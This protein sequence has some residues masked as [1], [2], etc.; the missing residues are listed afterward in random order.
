MDHT[1]A[2][3][4]RSERETSLSDVKFTDRPLPARRTREL[5]TEATSNVAGVRRR[6]ILARR[7]QDIVVEIADGERLTEIQPFWIALLERSDEPNVFMDPAL[8]RV[9]ADVYPKIKSVALL[10]WRKGN[11]RSELVGVW[12]FAVGSARHS[13]L[14]VRILTAPPFVHGYA[15]TPVVDR[16]CLDETLDAFLDWIAADEHL[17]KIVALEAM[18]TDGPIMKALIRVLAGRGKAPRILD[19]SLRPRLKSDLDGKNYLEKALSSSSRKKLRQHRRR[20]S[21]RGELS[22]VIVREPQAVCDALE[23]FLQIEASGWKGRQ[24][25]ALLCNDADAAFARTAIAALAEQGRASIHAL[26]LDQRPV[27]MQIVLRA[28]SAA[29]TWKI[30]YDETL[31]DFSPGMLLLEDYTAAFLND[32]AIAF[33]NSCTHDDRSFMSVWTEREEIANLWIDA[34]RGGS[35]S[36]ELLWRL[37]KGY[38]GLRTMVKNAYLKPRRTQPRKRSA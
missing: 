36:F 16:S 5:Q 24:G 27:S 8:V 28:G 17:P 23:D 3:A 20:L 4:A 12:A 31:H 2:E 38:S 18:A 22:S 32:P 29:F 15:A 19:R 14:P 21:E 30:A 7:S 34:R 10:A 35:V 25:T 33:V 37:Q 9:A 6:P 26:T 13:A 11:G 1:S